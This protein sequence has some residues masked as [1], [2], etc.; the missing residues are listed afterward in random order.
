MGTGSNDGNDGVKTHQPK[1]DRQSS[2]PGNRELLSRYPIGKTA[3]MDVLEKMLGLFNKMHIVKQKDVSFKTRKERAMFLRR[4]FREL[5][6]RGGFSSIP[7]PRNVSDRHIRAMIEIWQRDK[8]APGTIQTYLSYLR[9]LAI[10]IDKP[11]LVKPP[12]AYGLTPEEY[13][14]HDASNVDKSWSGHQVDI[15]AVLLAVKKYDRHVGAMLGL[16][17][18]F[19][20]RKKEAIMFR[21]CVRV[22]SFEET[23]LPPELRKAERYISIMAGSKGGRLRYIPLDSPERIAAIEHAQAIVTS[24]DDHMGQP[25][26][27]LKQAMRRFDYVMWRFGITSATLGVTAHGLRHEAL[28]DYYETITGEA[29][30]VRGGSKGLPK[31]LAN[32][33]RKEVAILAG[34]NR[35]RASGAYLGAI[36][37]PV[38]KNPDP[39]SSPDTDKVPQ[40]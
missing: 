21:P 11:G 25:R 16:I 20:L 14:R 23:R 32:T 24:R 3:P 4:F 36:R 12:E 5:R 19:G 8:L 27:N 39:A 22:V 33:A 28:I 38:L 30:P 15:D 1:R 29:A 7:D 18:A 31:E 34:H 40:A 26:L 17:R 2:A 37:K 13:K 9:A 6:E 10:W 35:K